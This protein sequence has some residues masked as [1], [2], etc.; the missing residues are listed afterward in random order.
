MLNSTEDCWQAS[1]TSAAQAKPPSD[2][3][4]D[5]FS[6]QALNRYGGLTATGVRKKASRSPSLAG[7]RR[8]QHHSFRETRRASCGHE[9]KRCKITGAK[10]GE[11]KCDP[12]RI[13]A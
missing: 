5:R 12:A 11:K 3:P 13:G 1:V 9:L 7:G 8:A 10:Q 4:D 2:A 6:R